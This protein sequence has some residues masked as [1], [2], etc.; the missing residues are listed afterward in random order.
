DLARQCERTVNRDGL[1][2]SVETDAA[3]RADRSRL[4]SA[5]ENLLQNA[6]EHGGDRVTV[7]VGW[8]ERG[9]GFY[10]AD[11]GA[12]IAASERDQVFGAGYSTDDTGTGLGLHIVGQVVEAHGWDIHVTESAAGG[13]RFEV[14]GVDR[15]STQ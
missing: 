3:I 12:G 2:L 15:L 4:A 1:T 9:D 7:T 11:D 8:L 10:L 14:T 6:D 5:L 13:A